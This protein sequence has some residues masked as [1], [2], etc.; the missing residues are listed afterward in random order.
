[1]LATSTPFALSAQYMPFTPF[2]GRAR[3]MLAWPDGH[4]PGT[5]YELQRRDLVSYGGVWSPW[6]TLAIGPGKT[7]FVDAGVAPDARYEYRIRTCF[8][9]ICSGW[10]I[11]AQ[12]T[13]TLPAAPSTVT[14]EAPLAGRVDLSWRNVAYESAYQ[15][16]RSGLVDGTWTAWQAL[17]EVAA[18][19]VR[20]RD[21]TTL[22]T[23]TYRYRLRA[24]NV[25]GCSPW[26]LVQVTVP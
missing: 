25:A 23:R 21:S 4:P 12:A 26:Q 2:T 6:T 10:A 8:G 1:M 16:Q 18:G 14:A 15:I 11:I 9:G 22:A 17:A 7:S 5:A 24:C 19:A 13:I 3:I 20:Y